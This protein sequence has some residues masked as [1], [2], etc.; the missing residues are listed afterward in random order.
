MEFFILIGIGWLIWF[1]FVREKKQD[2]EYPN[3]SSNTDPVNQSKHTSSQKTFNVSKSRKNNSKTNTKIKFG[4]GA[5]NTP[6][7]ITI[8]CPHCNSRIRIPS[9]RSGKVGCPHCNKKFEHEATV[10]EIPVID[11]DGINDAFTGVPINTKE[12]VYACECGVFYQEESF[13][14]LREENSSNC[15]ACNKSN[16]NLY[17]SSGSPA[18]RKKGKARPWKV[19]RNYNPN[20]ITL[21]NYK[22]YV[23][24]VVTFEGFVHGVKVS[25]RGSD[26]AVMFENKSWTKGF[27][28]VF[29]KGS[30]RKVGGSSF[31][32]SLKG[33]HIKVRGL[34]IKH[35]TFGY[36]IIINDPAMI[37]EISE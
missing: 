10:E 6:D 23:N 18:K 19:P 3:N 32:N 25:R 7:K 21:Q 27:K 17:S 22:R 28:L 9:G 8:L 16:I 30:V 36:E 37:L 34:L 4:V 12:T 29:F 1:I 24:Q 31:V 11:L 14:L 35:D 15:V 5:S 2:P 26:Y 20:S 33:K 13:V